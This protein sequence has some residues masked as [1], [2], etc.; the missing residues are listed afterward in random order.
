MMFR[1][2]ITAVLIVVGQACFAGPASDTVSRLQQGTIAILQSADA[3]D[4]EARYQGFL[5]LVQETHDMQ[6]ITRL[7]V[8]RAWS[9]L[10]PSQQDHLV[11]LL[12]QLS[13]ATYARRFKEY[14]EQQFAIT[15]EQPSRRD[16]KLVNAVLTLKDGRAISFSYLLKP[17]ATQWRIGNIMVD[18]VSDLALKRAE[19]R[20]Y[21]ADGGY[22]NLVMELEKQIRNV[23]EE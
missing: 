7:A 5:S 18:G 17:I 2:M 13:A 11:D 12:T 19:Y 1:A 9:T 4:Y 21:L 23:D 16:T 3:A 14:R 10:T 8:H 20:E 6:G 22:D 15:D